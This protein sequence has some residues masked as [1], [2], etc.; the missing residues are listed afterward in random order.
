MVNSV[1]ACMHV[2]KQA[3]RKIVTQTQ[4]RTDW[5]TAAFNLL[6]SYTGCYVHQLTTPPTDMYVD[7]HSRVIAS[8]SDTYPRLFKHSILQ[9][10][11]SCQWGPTA[12]NRP[13]QFSETRCSGWC[14]WCSSSS[15]QQLMELMEQART[16][17]DVSELH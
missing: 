3:W 5:A 11:H 17:T 9:N 6:L 1:G 12:S 16:L 15:L 8:Y 2:R 13:E 14:Q 7:H 4:K 10:H